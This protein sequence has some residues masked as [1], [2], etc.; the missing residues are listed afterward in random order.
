MR[1]NVITNFLTGFVHEKGL[2]YPTVCGYISAISKQHAAI[3]GVP[4]EQL[5][6]IKKLARANFIEKPPIPRYL[7]IWDVDRVLSLRPRGRSE[8]DRPYGHRVVMEDCLND[9]HTDLIQVCPSEMM[10]CKKTMI[11]IL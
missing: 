5:P 8:Y 6:E 11:S 9:L 3:N 7:E 2:L 4:L 10:R 1:R